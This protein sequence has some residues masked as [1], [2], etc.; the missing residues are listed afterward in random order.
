MDKPWH[1]RKG[2]Q[3]SLAF[4]MRKNTS[5]PRNYHVFVA[6]DCRDAMTGRKPSCGPVEGEQK[7]RRRSLVMDTLMRLEKVAC[8]DDDNDERK[9]ADDTGQRKQSTNVMSG[10]LKSHDHEDKG[11]NKNHE[12]KGAVAP[13]VGQSVVDDDITC[14]V[15]SSAERLERQRYTQQKMFPLWE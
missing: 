3:F 14:K 12:L 13:L 1:F 11:L 7:R 6:A 9:R 15:Y 5:F 10:N 2:Q 8:P 4:R